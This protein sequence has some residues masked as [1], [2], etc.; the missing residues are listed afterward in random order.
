[1][2]NEPANEPANEPLKEPLKGV[3]QPF[4]D[5][6][7]NAKQSL[8]K[9]TITEPELG[10]KEA[11]SLNSLTTYLMCLDLLYQN[12][13][14][15]SKNS[16]AIK[17]SNQVVL[18]KIPEKSREIVNTALDVIFHYF[19]MADLDKIPYQHFIKYHLHENQFL[20]K[21]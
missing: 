19:K 18:E 12:S 1:M 21:E 3:E 11:Q 9:N 20:L 6:I 2:T 4:I 10:T 17:P 5:A 7:I 15:N 14:K 16:S 8:Y 13:V